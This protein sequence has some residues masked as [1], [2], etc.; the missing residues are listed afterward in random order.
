MKWPELKNEKDLLIKMQQG[1]VCAFEKLYNHYKHPLALGFVKLLRNDALAQDALQDLFVRVWNNRAG[2][3]PSVPLRGYL[4]KIAQNLV[5]D[6]YRKASREKKFLQAFLKEVNQDAFYIDNT[7]EL[8]E[9]KEQFHSL[10][11]R[12][13]PQQRK[14]YT[15]HKIE[16][17]S[18]KEIAEIM[19]ISSSTINKHIHF[20]TKFI[21]RELAESQWVLQAMLAFILLFT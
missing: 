7:L 13:P 5:I 14:A 16:G 9:Q 4:F 18:Y 15:L 19:E 6:Y 10:L 3:D 12:L 17:K 11:H 2:V 8:K 20:A 1:D 21:S